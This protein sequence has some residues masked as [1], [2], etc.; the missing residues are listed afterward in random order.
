MFNNIKI[1][2]CVWLLLLNH[3]YLLFPCDDFFSMFFLFSSV[4]VCIP[5]KK[6]RQK[7]TSSISSSGGG[8][9]A[10][11]FFSKS[12]PST[13]RLGQHERLVQLLG[14]QEKREKAMTHP[15]TNMETPKKGKFWKINFPSQRG[16]L[17]V[18]HVSY[19]G[20]SSVLSFWQFICSFF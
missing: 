13:Q 1:W 12:T 4:L 7:F 14:S 16:K 17:Q 2:F 19:L 11:V 5:P 10:Y 3:H 15:K 9:I 20:S 18:N 8:A 6:K